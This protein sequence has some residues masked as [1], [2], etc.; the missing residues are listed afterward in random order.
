MTTQPHET[1]GVPG[2]GKA[3]GA[4]ALKANS[5]YLRGTIAQELA[6]GSDHFGKESVVLLKPHGTYQQDNRDDRA[7]IRAAG[8]TDRAN[9]AYS[10]M[11]RTKIPGGKLTSG[12]L[13]AELDLCDELGSSTL[14]VTTRQ[15]L[16][17]HG[18]LKQDLKQTIA[19]INEVQLTTL[20]ACGDN[21]RN[22]M[23]SPAPFN[24]DPVH[25]QMQEMAER[26]AA[27]LAPQTRAYHEIWLKDDGSGE[28]TLVGGGEEGA[29]VEP[30]YGAT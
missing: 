19:R 7:E 8:G 25:R 22:V 27:H 9:K 30:I 18:V 14:R 12:Q 16:Q 3:K 6:D 24:G 28:E 4:E 26:L 2:G 10:Y 11:V 20:G 13:L 17:L 15:G 1:N 23:C 5:N 21:N 29:V